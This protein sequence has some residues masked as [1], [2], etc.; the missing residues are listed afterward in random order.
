M[1]DCEPPRALRGVPLSSTNLWLNSTAV[2]T[3]LHY[4]PHHNL[5]CVVSGEK[6]VCL[7]PPTCTEQLRPFS[8]FGESANHSQLTDLTDSPALQA[9]TAQARQLQAYVDVTL[10]AGDALFIPAGWWH[11]VTSAAQSAAINYWW[12]MPDDAFASS[13]SSA[14]H[15]HMQQFFVRMRAYRVAHDAAIASVA[16]CRRKLL[17]EMHNSTGAHASDNQQKAKQAYRHLLACGAM[18]V[19][20]TASQEH[21]SNGGSTVHK[22]SVQP[23]AFDAIAFML[24]S[25]LQEMTA[26]VGVAL[27]Q[28]SKASVRHWVRSGMSDMAAFCLTTFLEDGW[29]DSAQS[30]TSACRS[31]PCET[32]DNGWLACCARVA[33]GFEATAAD[34]TASSTKDEATSNLFEIL[35]G[36]ASQDEVTRTLA[37]G[38]ETFLTRTW[39]RL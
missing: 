25:S 30:S 3:S 27:R 18:Q 34:C 24:C 21:E 5:L 35:Y 22:S 23:V 17:R 7:W 13:A 37:H 31:V 32:I 15:Q 9:A 28:N 19:H 33:V 26:F 6:R 4:D 8:A 29:P 39:H 14:Q 10:A 12:A 16:T 11:L 2:T 1:Q 20:L 38:K 36:A